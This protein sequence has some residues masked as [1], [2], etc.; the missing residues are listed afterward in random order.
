MDQSEFYY[1]TSMLLDRLGY[2]VNLDELDLE[3]GNKRAVR[4][5]KWYDRIS[6]GIEVFFDLDMPS[7][8][9][10]HIPFD[11]FSEEKFAALK[12]D[13][14]SL[15][16]D[17]PLAGLRYAHGKPV[18]F[19][20]KVI[21][22][23]NIPAIKDL[24][25][26]LHTEFAHFSNKYEAALSESGYNICDLCLAFFNSDAF[27]EARRMLRKNKG[28]FWKGT[29]TIGWLFNLETLELVTTKGLTPVHLNV[30]ETTAL[31]LARN[32]RAQSLNAWNPPSG[33]ITGGAVGPKTYLQFMRLFA[34][35]T[36]QGKVELPA[37]FTGS[38][39]EMDSGRE[40][41]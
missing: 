18:V 9:P 11:K 14:R 41:A 6:T 17:L 36:E 16:R 26:R 23:E 8:T 3:S 20:A 24:F 12:N 34:K 22:N 25:E 38:F 40:T 29:Y 2:A 39:K 28:G 37:D 5:K 31:L 1:S 15:T 13:W 10:V 21:S 19:G 27:E 33:R 35:L 4:L 30:L 7:G 32:K